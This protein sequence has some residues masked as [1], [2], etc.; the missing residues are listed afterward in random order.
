M[1]ILIGSARKAGPLKFSYENIINIV[2]IYD[3]HGSRLWAKQAT[4]TSRH[5]N[6]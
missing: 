3:V 6:G 2:I 1:H 5:C 4:L